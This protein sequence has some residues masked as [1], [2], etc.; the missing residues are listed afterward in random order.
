M[1]FEFG[2]SIGSTTKKPRTKFLNISIDMA[3]WRVPLLLKNIE[4][5]KKIARFFEKKI[6]SVFLLCIVLKY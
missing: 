5:N 3:V 1:T 6:I 2:M 4:K